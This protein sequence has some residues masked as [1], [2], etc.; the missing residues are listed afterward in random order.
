MCASP[1]SLD[2]FFKIAITSIYSFHGDVIKFCGDAILCVFEQDRV[3]NAR[4]T[5]M[6]AVRCA[7]ELKSKLRFFKAAE[8]VVLD[9]K[10]MLAHGDIVGNYVGDRTLNH[11][12]FLVTGEPMQQITDAE[13][14]VVPGDIILSC[15]IYGVVSTDVS[16]TNVMGKDVSSAAAT[17]AG[18]KL[19]TGLAANYHP[20]PVPSS[21]TAVR[22]SGE[23]ATEQKGSNRPF[24]HTVLASFVPFVHSCVWH[25]GSH[26]PPTTA[27]KQPLL[28]MFNEVSVVEKLSNFAGSWT[29][30]ERN[31]SSMRSRVSR[32]DLCTIIFIN[33]KSPKL[34][35]KD[36]ATL[37][38]GLNEAFLDFY[39]PTVS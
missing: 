20:L 24:V 38:A 4:D 28:E 33:L 1:Q 39:H 16:V 14:Y 37:L 10:L 15:E 22:L 18:F 30:L 19:L 17:K 36:P 27:S 3:T 32:H 34:A 5:A 11:F 26:L 25:V 31:S 23:Q 9:L 6:N 35:S 12:E 7:V 13:D 21:S 2:D 8:N 29:R